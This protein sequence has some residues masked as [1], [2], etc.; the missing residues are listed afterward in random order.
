MME[1]FDFET[2]SHKERGDQSVTFPLKKGRS[3][4]D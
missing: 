4:D 3:Y 2:G 1:E